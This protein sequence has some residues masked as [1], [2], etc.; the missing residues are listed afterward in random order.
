MTEP[1]PGVIARALERAMGSGCQKSRRG[2]AVFRWFVPPHPLILGSGANRP[3]QGAC[4]GSAECRRDC[5]KICLHAEQVALLAAGGDAEGAEM[6]HVKV[7]AT[8][9]LVPSATGRG[10]VRRSGTGP[11]R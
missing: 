3:A 9:A 8:D 10:S 6:V 2:A 7:D 4:D 11:E 1:P 5:S